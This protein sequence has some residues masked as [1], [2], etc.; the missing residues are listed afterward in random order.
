MSEI[1]GKAVCAYIFS[2]NLYGPSPRHMFYVFSMNISWDGCRWIS[3]VMVKSF[4]GR[5]V[6]WQMLEV[7]QIR[8]CKD[9]QGTILVLLYQ[10]LGS[11]AVRWAGM[12]LDRLRGSKVPCRIR[13]AGD[14]LNIL[15]QWLRERERVWWGWS[16]WN[17]SES[18]PENDQT[19]SQV[20]C[21]FSWSYAWL[22]CVWLE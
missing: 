10:K 13:S 21:D 9:T 3:Q 12:Q 2:Y 11:W 8:G 15:E 7:T 17:K 14:Q 22:C 18:Y 16:T 20:I 6:P 5:D 19:S 4:E 1:Q